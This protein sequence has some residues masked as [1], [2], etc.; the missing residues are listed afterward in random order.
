MTLIGPTSCTCCWCGAATSALDTANE[1]LDQARRYEKGERDYRAICGR[2]ASLG[3]A[4]WIELHNQR[5]DLIAQWEQYF[6]AVDVLLC[7]VSAT[8]ATTHDTET[9]FGERQ[10]DVDGR[11]RPILEQWFWAG[12]ASGPYLPATAA[13]IGV[14]GAGLPVGIQIVAPTGHDHRSIAFA[15]VIE[16]VIGGYEP[17][18][19]LRR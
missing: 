2:G 15:Q 12:I 8:P 5:A 13:P 10:I 3:H 6:A 9:P 14:T 18:P 17:P 1:D 16:D 7:P 11:L 4:A 19:L